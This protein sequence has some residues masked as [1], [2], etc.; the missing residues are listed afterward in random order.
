MNKGI[1]AEQVIEA[2]GPDCDK[3]LMVRDYTAPGSFNYPRYVIEFPYDAEYG[4]HEIIALAALFGAT[5]I[6]AQYVKDGDD[7]FTVEVTET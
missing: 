2:L 7:P 6:S 1:T 4:M 5:G 3:G